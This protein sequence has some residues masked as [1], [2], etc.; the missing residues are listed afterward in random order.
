MV[1]DNDV[2]L[3]LAI[4]ATA[5]N[6]VVVIFTDL[7]EPERLLWQAFP[8]GSWV[9][10]RECDPVADDVAGAIRWGPDRL[11]RAEV[12][13]APGVRLRGARITPAAIAH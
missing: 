2:R 11:V 12:I 6:D 10:L 3:P 8:S 4:Q 1:P 5:F 13:R 9:D 7:N